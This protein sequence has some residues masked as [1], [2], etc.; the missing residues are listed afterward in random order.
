LRPTPV[1]VPDLGAAAEQLSA[2]GGRL[3]NQPPEDGEGH[4]YVFVEPASAGGVLLEL[5]QESAS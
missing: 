4:L 5:I 1:G 3:L 2:A